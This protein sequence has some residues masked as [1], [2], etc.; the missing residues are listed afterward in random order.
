MKF[1]IITG[2]QLLEGLAGGI[3]L[4]LFTLIFYKLLLHKDKNI[5]SVLI[6]GFSFWL[7]WYFRKISIN[8]YNFYKAKY[9]FTFPNPVIDI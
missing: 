2:A 6:I 7:T 3:G 4:V 1:T 5:G 9:H 8:L